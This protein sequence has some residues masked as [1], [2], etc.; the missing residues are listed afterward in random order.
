M[1]KVRIIQ[2]TDPSGKTLYVIQQKPFFFKWWWVDAWINNCICC[3]DTFPTL[4]EVRKNLCY[5][6]GTPTIE[7]V[8]FENNIY[9]TQNKCIME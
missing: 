4:E 3:Q 1:R 2:R 7:K 8:V 5:F 6:D 9:P